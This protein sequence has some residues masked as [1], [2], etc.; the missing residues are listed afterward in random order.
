LWSTSTMAAGALTSS[1]TSG[2][3]FSTGAA[4]PNYPPHPLDPPVDHDD[5]YWSEEMPFA[6]ELLQSPPPASSST[7]STL[8]GKSDPKSTFGAGG[9][10]YLG[11]SAAATL[12]Q[13][14]A[15]GQHHPRLKLLDS[16]RVSSSQQPNPHSDSLADQLQELR[17]FGASLRLGAT[18]EQGSLSGSSSSAAANPIT[19]RS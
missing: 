17:A 19:L 10:S 6:V 12:A 3:F 14:C 16:S 18:E 15:T 8:P 1:T 5:S 11:H 4:F 13:K 7:T 9:S 2:A